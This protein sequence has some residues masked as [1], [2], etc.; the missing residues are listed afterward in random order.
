MSV[1]VEIQAGGRRSGPP[2]SSRR[3]ALARFAAWALGLMLAP[4]VPTS[5]ARDGESSGYG[6]PFGGK[7]NREVRTICGHGCVIEW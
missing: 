1:A 3:S 5:R 6:P 4:S 2:L 7:L